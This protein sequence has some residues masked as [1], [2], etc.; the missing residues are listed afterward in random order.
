M[1]LKS[2]IR[3]REE[4]EI[5]GWEKTIQTIKLLKSGKILRRVLDPWG[6]L[7]SLRFQWNTFCL[8]WCDKLARNNYNN[9]DNNNKES[10]KKYKYLDFARELKKLCNIKATF[11]PIVIVAI[12][13]NTKGLVQGLVT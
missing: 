10:E 6:D 13:T 1:I 5:W 9:N 12:F 4:M 8:S 7:L 11:T 2:L 3:V